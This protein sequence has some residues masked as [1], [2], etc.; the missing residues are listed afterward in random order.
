[1]SSRSVNGRPGGWPSNR[2]ATLFNKPSRCS[3]VQSVPMGT[4]Y[5]TNVIITHII[6]TL[7]TLQGLVIRH[8]IFTTAKVTAEDNWF[9]FI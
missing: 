9:M 7:Y 4:F 5:T 6:V 8:T 3:A 1:M 2:R